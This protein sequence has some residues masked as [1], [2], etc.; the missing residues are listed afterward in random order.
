MCSGNWY[1]KGLTVFAH[2]DEGARWTRSDVDFVHQFP[3]ER[4]P[5]TSFLTFVA[6][7]LDTAQSVVHIKAVTAVTDRNRH[8]KRNRKRTRKRDSYIMS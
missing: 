2:L 7:F 1:G 8:R 3:D 4:Q 6:F 5:P